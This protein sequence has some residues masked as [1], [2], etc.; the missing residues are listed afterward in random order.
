MRNSRQRRGVD[1]VMTDR[2]TK[3]RG[4]RKS[5]PRHGKKSRPSGVAVRVTR[6]G[7]IHMRAYGP[8]APDLRTVVPE[9][10]GT[11]DPEIARQDREFDAMV[12]RVR[13]GAPGAGDEACATCRGEG[14]IR[15]S[16]TRE[17]HCC[18][19]CGGEGAAS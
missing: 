4:A 2:S 16:K 15:D 19:D 11:T 8:A 9:L 18:P 5:K 12:D 1:R 13:E 10:F 6:D 14:R 7:G 17:Q 3:N